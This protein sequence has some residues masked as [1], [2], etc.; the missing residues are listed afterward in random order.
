MLKSVSK[1]LLAIAVLL[2]IGLSW[3]LDYY[4]GYEIATYSFY[5]IP[6][7]FAVWYIGAWSGFLTAVLCGAA[8]W[9]ADVADRHPYSSSSI[10]IENALARLTFFLFVAVSFSYFRRTIA[11]A[12]EKMK[13]FQGPLPVCTSCRKI[14]GKD[15]Y[16]C[17]FETYIRENT[18]A[19]PQAKMCPEC[20]R[21][22]YVGTVVAT[23]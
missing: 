6:V 20:S 1:T 8:T 3:A 2:Q 9:W 14:C 21:R 15:G 5:A 10:A 22:R 23:Q 13:A 16:W 11:Q 7:A 12:K 19:V 17:D 18:E 4:S